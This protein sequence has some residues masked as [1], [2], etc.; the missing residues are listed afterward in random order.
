MWNKIEEISIQIWSFIWD[1][2]SSVG[3]AIWGFLTN[4]SHMET[5]VPI[6]TYIIVIFIGLFLLMKLLKYVV[7]FFGSLTK[8]VVGRSL[9][10]TLIFA[11]IAMVISSFGIYMKSVAG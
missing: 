5:I 7:D 10:K 11:I 9:K 8:E 4:F 6:I 1:I 3:S 2:L